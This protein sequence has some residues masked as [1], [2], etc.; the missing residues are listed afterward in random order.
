MHSEEDLS[1]QSEH[2]R[3]VE[4]DARDAAGTEQRA[5]V[6]FLPQGRVHIQKHRDDQQ[7]DAD[8]DRAEDDGVG[9]LAR[10]D[11]KGLFFVPHRPIHRVKHMLQSRRRR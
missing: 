6:V 9:V 3:S 7:K 5:S 4:Q 1:E 11:L 2:D 10:H 8:P